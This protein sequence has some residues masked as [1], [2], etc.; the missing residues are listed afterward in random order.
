MATNASSS[1]IPPATSGSEIIPADWAT[2]VHSPIVTLHQQP[3]MERHISPEEIS[4]R[5]CCKFSLSC[6]N[7]SNVIIDLNFD[8]KSQY[9]GLV[10]LSNKFLKKHTP[11]D[12]RKMCAKYKI[13]HYK[14]CKMENPKFTTPLSF[15]PL[16]FSTCVRS[17]QS[18]ISHLF[19]NTTYVSSFFTFPWYSKTLCYSSK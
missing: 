1:T 19:Y 18:F 4:L 2:N 16:I 13:S 6:G 5:V 7:V 15:P 12:V 9:S 17:S 10:S 11:D 14:M 3:K 8:L